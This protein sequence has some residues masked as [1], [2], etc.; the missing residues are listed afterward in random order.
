MTVILAMLLQGGCK[1]VFCVS[2]VPAAL[3]KEFCPREKVSKA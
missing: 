3:A 1:S 2:A